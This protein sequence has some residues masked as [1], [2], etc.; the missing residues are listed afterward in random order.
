M[1]V[2]FTCSFLGISAKHKKKC[3]MKFPSPIPMEMCVVW[4][5]YLCL[6]LSLSRSLSLLLSESTNQPFQSISIRLHWKM[7]VIQCWSENWDK[8]GWYW[9]WCNVN[10][11]N[12]CL[13]LLRCVERAF[14]KRRRCAFLSVLPPVR[15]SR[16]IKNHHHQQQ[17]QKCYCTSHGKCCEI[18]TRCVCIFCVCVC[19]SIL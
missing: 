4:K 12:R 7:K 16:L 17:H 15:I 14:C 2:F 18:F 5:Y 3:K 1:S 6:V 11:R 10:K 8:Y 13:A 19:V 9:V